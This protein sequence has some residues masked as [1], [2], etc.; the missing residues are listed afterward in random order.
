MIRRIRSIILLAMAIAP[1]TLHSADNARLTDGKR[2]ICVGRVEPIDGEIEVSAQISGTLIAVP[3]RE[4]E[5]VSAGAVLA[6]IDAPRE[7]AALELTQAKLARVKA[8]RGVEEIAAAEAMREAI[9]AELTWTESAYRRALALGSKQALAEDTVEE[10]KQMAAAL[11][12]RHA[13]AIKQVEALRRGPLPEEVA[14][15]EAELATARAAFELRLV[16]AIA[17]GVVLEL[18]RHPGDSVSVTYPT[19]ILRMAN[20]RR[21]RV[22][23]EVSEQDAF[24]IKPGMT[25]E[26]VAFGENQVSGRL[27]VKTVLPA[28]APRRL[29]EPDATARMDTRTVQA[30]CEIVGDAA[31]FSGQRITVT[32]R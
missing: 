20:V 4:G 8:G 31:A 3:L 6:E 23:I 19:P 17:E 12:Q 30:L 14:L 29:F 2:I 28:F 27:V 13:A 5:W 11:R 1:F 7:R 18:H 24:W 21:L 10:R 15:A 22:R 26:F 25:G 16:R 32:I 9:A